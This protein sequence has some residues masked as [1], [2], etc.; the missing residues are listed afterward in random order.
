MSNL[1]EFVRG[2]LSRLTQPLLAR[3]ARAYV[4]GPELADAIEASQRLDDRG[5]PSTIGYWNARE[6]TPEGIAE[7]QL[8]ALT[9]LGSGTLDTYASVKV[10]AL[11]YRRDLVAR[12]AAQAQRLP[13]AP[14]RIHFDSHAPE[15]QEETLALADLAH[16]Q[17]TRVGVTLP[18]RWHRS[19]ADADRVVKQGHAVRVVKGQWAE[20]GGPDPR[21][22]FLSV[23]ERLAGRASHVAVA[24][25]DPVLATEA[26]GLLHRCGTSAELELLLGLP[27]RVA[28]NAADELGARVRV[29]VPYGHGWLPYSLGQAAK[30]PT[31]AWWIVKDALLGGALGLP[32]RR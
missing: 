21:D 18:G 19:L 8:A 30:R 27:M 25:H 23:I 11:N 15:T 6:E 29:Y 1:R 7:V 13:P 22:G 5:Y 17:G 14:R 10:P 4:S 20:E 24:T 12:V 28:V 9:A 26:L 2:K 3:A 31:V 32:R 16:A